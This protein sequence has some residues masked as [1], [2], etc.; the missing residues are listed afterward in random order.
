M[1]GLPDEMQR[2]TS[3]PGP[4][5]PMPKSWRRWCAIWHDR[6]RASLLVMQLDGFA[7]STWMTVSS[8]ARDD[9]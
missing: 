6:V 9:G 1:K 3:L 2:T 8:V 4:E 5:A 7:A